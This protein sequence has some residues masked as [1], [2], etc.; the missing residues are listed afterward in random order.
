MIRTVLR[1]TL[2]TLLLVGAPALLAQHHEHDLPH[3]DTLR[4]DSRLF[5]IMQRGTLEGRFRQYN[6]ATVND[7][8]PADYYAIAFGGVLGYASDR[9]RGL[10]FKM[11]GGFTFDLASSRFEEPDPFTGGFSRYEIGLFDVTDPKNVEDLAYLHEFQ[12]NY[13]SR[14]ERTEAIFGKQEIHT[15]FLNPQDGR[16]HPTLF[17]GI[18]ARHRLKKGPT[19]QGGW[20]YR[21]APRS[22]SKWYHVEESTHLYPVGRNIL[23]EPSD[24]GENQ[25]SLG[26]FVFSAKEELAKGVTLTVWDI[27]VENMFNTAMLQA[28][29]GNKDRGW[30]LQAMGVH[31][32]NTASGVLAD[33][34]QAYMP[35]G[36][37]GLAFSTRLRHVPGRFRWQL[38]Y[39]RISDRGRFLMPR[40]WGRDPFFTFLPRERNEGL[41]DVHATSVNLILR[42]KANTLRTEVDGGAYWLPAVTE[43]RL[44]KYAMPS[45]A[46]FNLNMMYTFQEKW[47][48]LAV[49]LLYLYKMPLY[50]QGLSDALVH[51]KVDMHHLDLIVN[52]AF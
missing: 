1:T 38:N 36:E 20:L 30:S 32:T 23:G 29:L 10:Q 48:G 16:M 26:I 15:P 31:Q 37:E 17:E 28:D 49:Q 8:P 9:W 52:Y 40:E 41:G 18:W 3:S 50:E 19:L 43:A 25:E 44:N 46:Q 14:D 22:T 4:Q 33:P 12:L 5:E 39:T 6:M 21:V 11:A 51:N 2:A 34:E 45:Y 27:F 47:K 7:G 13:L 42:N 24:H 35:A